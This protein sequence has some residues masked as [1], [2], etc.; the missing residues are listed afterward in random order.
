MHELVCLFNERRIVVWRRR[1]ILG[2]ERARQK[3]QAGSIKTF[4]SAAD[5]RI[6]VLSRDGVA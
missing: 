3:Q 6:V 4:H 1:W 2:E 5:Y